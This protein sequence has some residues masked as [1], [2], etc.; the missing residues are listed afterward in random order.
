MI[1]T[2]LT[3]TIA[4]QD[5]QIG[6]VELGSHQEDDA[7]KN[8]DRIGQEGA[9]EPNSTKLEGKPYVDKLNLHFYVDL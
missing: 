7:V 3:L 8:V 9:Q 4:V 6:N 1:V 2:H 5:R